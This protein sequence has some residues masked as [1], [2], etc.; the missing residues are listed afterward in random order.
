MTFGWT[1]SGPRRASQTWRCPAH[2]A[3]RC[4]AHRNPEAS[5]MLRPTGARTVLRHDLP[6]SLVLLLIA[7]PLSLGI[8]IASGAPVMAGLIAAGIGG[9][10]A[11]LLWG[12]P[13]QGSGPSPPLTPIV[14][15]L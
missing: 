9:I 2:Q 7:I 8:A 5:R 4:R 1:P 3:D 11:G 12:S 13:F 14:A 6:A 15:A 10:V